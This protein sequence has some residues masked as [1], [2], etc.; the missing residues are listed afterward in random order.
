MKILLYFLN[1]IAP[2]LFVTL[3]WHLPDNIFFF[4]RGNFFR[5]SEFSL[6]CS[7]SQFLMNLIVLLH[8]LHAL[9]LLVITMSLSY[10]FL[11]R[12]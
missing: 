6:V 3:V 8:F 10:L 7:P 11:C 2:L 5:P 12:F 9:P 1:T 4:R